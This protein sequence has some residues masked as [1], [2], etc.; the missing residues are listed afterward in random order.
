M[1]IIISGKVIHGEH[2]GKKLGFPTANLD[3]REYSRKKMRIKLGVWIG[4][5]VIIPNSEF[6]MPNKNQ[7]SKIK[8]LKFYK[9]GIVISPLNKYQLPKIEAHLI[10]FKGNLYGKK[11]SLFL[12]KYLRPFKKFDNVKQLKAQ[13][14]KDIRAVKNTKSQTLNPKQIPIIKIQNNQLTKV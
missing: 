4:K 14:K 9:A 3:R 13:I 1:N 12:L 10:G 7:K 2:Y 11:L 8:N 5:V 6:L